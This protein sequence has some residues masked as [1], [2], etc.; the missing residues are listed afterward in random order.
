MPSSAAP[1]ATRRLYR[2]REDRMVAGVA[3]GL[4]DHLGIDVKLLRA[5]FVAT[6]LLG[7]FGV[8]LYAAFWAVVPQA[9]DDPQRPE[10]VSSRPQL[11]GF[12]L[13]GLTML[14]IAQLLGFGPGL[15][16]PAAAAITGAA[17]LWRQADEMQR[18]RWRSVTARQ[19]RLIAEAP[20]QHAWLRYGAGLLLVVAGMASFLAAHD[21]LTEVRRAALPV[22][23][24]VLG[25]V[26]A[27]GPWM[28]QTFH[29]LTDE[30]T[31]RIRE[32]E[33]V[34]IA[35]RVHDSMLQTLTLI[36]RRADDPD[37]V[38]RL[39]RRSERELR[40]WLYTPAVPESLRA[41]ILALVADAEDTYAVTIDMVMVGEATTTPAVD[42]LVQATR[43]SIVNS[44][45]HSGAAQI[46]VYAEADADEITVFV[47]DRGQ[48]FA[49]EEI[50]ADRFG[51]RESV[52]ARMQRHGG[53]AEIR[54]TPGNGTEVRL[55]LPL[56]E[57]S[58]P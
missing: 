14:L 37:E 45:K 11:V 7:G 35:G 49:V 30:R 43:E 40:G 5:G 55:R 41:A 9:S 29:Q 8:V 46:S 48:G 42:A 44:A 10:S 51:V 39:V 38:L 53:D 36:Q 16:W 24:V 23:V 26:L 31:A 58:H 4:A 18:L 21:A 52:V 15:L 6:V 28:L 50:P 20:G 32:H 47:R 33:R 34:E 54:S 22:F 56:R 13:L 17:I 1:P 19:S 25:L 3:S 57:G 12:A 2:R 27:V